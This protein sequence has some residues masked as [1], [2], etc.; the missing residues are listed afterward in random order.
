M[1]AKRSAAVV[2]TS[3][4]VPACT[5]ALSLGQFDDGETDYCLCMLFERQVSCI[6]A[7][8]QARWHSVTR[9]HSHTTA[10]LPLLATCPKMIELVCSLVQSSAKGCIW[11]DAS[12]HNQ[13]SFIRC[14][15]P[16]ILFEKTP[17]QC[18]MMCCPSMSSCK[19]N[20]RDDASR[21]TVAMSCAY[22]A[23]GQ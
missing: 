10:S 4:K 5:G 11:S 8:S 20:A 19:S 3:R 18:G 22:V 17:S 12:L 16:L 23:T 2:P 6:Q 9:A 15:R 7:D 21:T 14:R 1:R 13:L